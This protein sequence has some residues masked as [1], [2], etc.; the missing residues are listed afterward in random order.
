MRIKHKVNVRIANDTDMYNLLFGPDDIRSEVTID[1][2]TRMSSGLI[3]VAMNTNENLPLGD[4]TAVKGIFL[5]VNQEAVIKLNGGTE[6]IQMRKPST[7]ASVYARLFLEGDIS[8]VNIAAP[9]L[10]DLEGIYC[11]WGDAAV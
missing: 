6:T 9:A 1:S 11:V 4:V 3:K 10:A 2:Y 8:Q 7:S 5:Q